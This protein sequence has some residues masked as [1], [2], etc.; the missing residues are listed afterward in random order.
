[1]TALG[2]CSSRSSNAAHRSPQA[3]LRSR[4][5]RFTASLAQHR[6]LVS[7]ARTASAGAVLC[8]PAGRGTAAG[9]WNRVLESCPQHHPADDCDR[10][11]E[12]KVS[13]HAITESDTSAPQTAPSTSRS[14]CTKESPSREQRVGSA[15]VAQ[16][17]ELRRQVTSA[18]RITSSL[19]LFDERSGTADEAVTSR[20]ICSPPRGA[21]VSIPV[22][23]RVAGTGRLYR[24]SSPA[25]RIF[26]RCLRPIAGSSRRRERQAPTLVGD[27]HRELF[28]LSSDAGSRVRLEHEA[29]DLLTAKRAPAAR[30]LRGELELTFAKVTH[31]R[32]GH[33]AVPFD[34][35]ERA[36]TRRCLEPALAGDR[37]DLPAVLRA[38]QTSSPLAPCAASSATRCDAIDLA[39]RA[40]RAAAG[41]ARLASRADRRRS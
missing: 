9:S 15:T 36:Q 6:W 3:R 4:A 8:P 24:R 31:G 13:E 30:R 5:R 21:L 2:G 20:T 17:A 40:A 1:M 41:I 32:A 19:E 22:H 35:G 39:A 10:R 38:E 29:A 28:S 14:S 27:R 7:T 18:R 34:G 23:A 16:I 37:A 12:P 11:G 26:T 33:G 25:S